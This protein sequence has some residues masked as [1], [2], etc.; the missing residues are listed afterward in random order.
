MSSRVKE[1]DMFCVNAPGLRGHFIILVKVENELLYF[2]DTVDKIYFITSREDIHVAMNMN[3]P[4]P[5]HK[6]PFVDYVK[7]IPDNIWIPLKQ[8]FQ[9]AMRTK[10]VKNRKIMKNF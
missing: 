2:Y 3:A 8:Y 10:S 1:G 9:V 5:T 7:T 6:I 4:H